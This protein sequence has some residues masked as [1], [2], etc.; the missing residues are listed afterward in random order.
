M[1]LA[2]AGQAF[3]E[4]GR[5]TDERSIRNLTELMDQLRSAVT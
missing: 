1:M 5:I 2:D 3:D 4:N